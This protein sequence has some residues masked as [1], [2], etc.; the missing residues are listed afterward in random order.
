MAKRLSRGQATLLLVT[1]L[2][3]VSVLCLYMDGE[4]AVSPGAAQAASAGSPTDLLSNGM[5]AAPSPPRSPVTRLGEDELLPDTAGRGG[6]RLVLNFESCSHPPSIVNL[7]SQ[8]G[9]QAATHLDARTWS[10]PWTPDGGTEVSVEA[11]FGSSAVLVLTAIK[12]ERI[13]ITLPSFAE[14]TASFREVESTWHVD[15]TPESPEGELRAETTTPIAVDGATAS[16]HLLHSGQPVSSRTERATLLAPVGS[17][18]SISAS[19]DGMIVHP[20]AYPHITPPA[21]LE[22]SGRETTG[23]RVVGKLPVGTLLL[24]YE[25]RDMSTPLVQARVRRP[26]AKS[27]TIHRRWE[28]LVAGTRHHLECIL[29]DGKRA[30]ASFETDAVGAAEVVVDGLLFELP[31]LVVIG[32]D[33]KLGHLY[34]RTTRAWQAIP[35]DPAD[36]NR[37]TGMLM[38]SD[39]EMGVLRVVHGNEPWDVGFVVTTTGAIGRIKWALTDLIN[40]EWL[41]GATTSI[42]PSHVPATS[43]IV[44]WR[45]S[46]AAAGTTGEPHWLEVAAGRGTTVELQSARFW[47]VPELRTRLWTKVI[48]GESKGAT[49][50][51]ESPF[52]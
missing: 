50:E 29:P 49:S 40:P 9:R 8:A 6:E 27:T 25:D 21:A 43:G 15:W 39:S 33:H 46:F 13:N 47:S 4:D 30:S 22:F 1:L 11:E 31:T 16:L 17:L 37:E 52:Q 51:V 32:K 42:R 20:E 44:A 18:W 35:T 26:E 7:V 41:A 12:Q 2:I 28:P 19:A 45:L 38:L 48:D 10:L 3:S 24:L 36:F 5:A 23:V 14:V 34:L